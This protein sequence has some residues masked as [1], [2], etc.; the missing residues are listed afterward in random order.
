VIIAA[1][2][3]GPPRSGNGGY[4][5]GLVAS[6][7]DAPVAKVRLHR[8]PPLDTELTVRAGPSPDARI[9]G[10]AQAVWVYAGDDLIASAQ[11]GRVEHAVA[12]IGFVE[13][14]DVA[15]SYLGF[16]GH[17][18]PTCFV[19]GPQRTDGLGIFP[20]RIAEGRTAAPFVVPPEI[21]PAVVWAC[22][23]CPGGWAT[24]LETQP[25]VLGELAVRIDALPSPGDEC[26][27]VGE[28]T[29]EEGRRAFVRTTLYSPAGDVLATGEAT[30][31]AIN[32]ADLG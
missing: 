11:P 21:S 16:T 7:V 19:C 22:L 18:F 1:R 25:R 8:P 9:A 30:W 17:P 15:K 3:N 13:A 12:G 32:P 26:V 4:T 27:V 5:S 23:D 28:M 14:T 2:Y 29:G 31:V 24:P 20:G 10:S 6:H